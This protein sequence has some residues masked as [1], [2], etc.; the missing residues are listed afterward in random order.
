MAMLEYSRFEND[1]IE[2]K[3]GM[4]E[5]KLWRSGGPKRSGNILG[6]IV[7]IFEFFNDLIRDFDFELVFDSDHDFDVIQF[8]D[9]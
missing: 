9:T 3:E 1:K 8:I 4:K 6:G 5:L 2:I 7:D